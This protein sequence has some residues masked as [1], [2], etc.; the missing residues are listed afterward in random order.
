MMRKI[1][2]ALVTVCW[3]VLSFATSEEQILYVDKS[4][5]PGGDGE[6]P[7]TAFTTIAAALDKAQAGWTVK[8][9]PGDYDAEEAV[10]SFGYTNRVIIAKKVHLVS[11]QGKDVTHIVG[12]HARVPGSTT[13]G[14]GPDAVRCIRVENA[15]YG[16]IIE[17]FTLRD[18]ACHADDNDDRSKGGGLLGCNTSRRTYLVDCV[19]SNC[20]AARGGTA[21]GATVVRS[22]LIRNKGGNAAGRSSNF[23]NALIVDND[24]GEGSCFYDCTFFGC[25]VA[26]NAGSS[27]L[28]SMNGGKYKIYNSVFS[29]NSSFCG[30]KTSL[31]AD[32]CVL[33]APSGSGAFT[34]TGTTLGNSV[35]SLVDGY[36]F[37]APLVDDWRLLPTDASVGL[38][39]V[40]N[41]SSA[42][43]PTND[44]VD[45]LVDL[46]GISYSDKET[47]NAGALQT[48]AAS[49]ATG[50]LQFSVPCVANG[51]AGAVAGLYAFAESTPATFSVKPVLEDGQRVHRI[52]RDTVHGAVVYPDLN[53]LFYLLAPPPGVIVT[54]TVLLAH[55]VLYVSETGTDVDNDGLDPN[56]P[57][58]TLQKAADLAQSYDVVSAAA[59]TYDEGGVVRNGVSNRLYTTKDIRIVGAGIGKSFIKGAADPDNPSGKVGDGRGPKACRCVCLG[60]AAAVQGFTLTDGHTDY[61]DD[62]DK[63]DGSTRGGGFSVDST[64]SSRPTNRYLLDCAVTNCSGRT[65]GGVYCGTLIRCRISDCYGSGGGIRYANLVS[66]VIDHGSLLQTGGSES[67]YN[68][69]CSANFCTFIENPGEGHVVPNAGEGGSNAG[70]YVTNSVLVIGNGKFAVASSRIGANAY[71][72]I[73]NAAS[74]VTAIENAGGFVGDPLLYAPLAGDGRL[75]SCSRAIGGGAAD[76]ID[77]RSFTSGFGGDPVLFVDGQPTMGAFQTLVDAVAVPKPQ[78]GSYGSLP[79][80][81]GVAPGETLTITLADSTRPCSGFVVNGVTNE[82]DAASFTYTGSANPVPSDPV[83]VEPVYLPHWYVDA[84][85]GDDLNS[86]FTAG[87]AKQSLKGVMDLGKSLYVGDTVHAAEGVY[88]NGVMSFGTGATVGT[89]VVI[90]AGVTLQADG[91]RELTIIEGKDATDADELGLGAD[92]VRCVVITDYRSVLKGFTIRGGRTS[93]SGTSRD[94]N[95]CGG[96]VYS[97]TA[98]SGSLGP[99]VI[100]CVITNCTAGY[101][102]GGYG[103]IDYIGSL[104]VENR[105]KNGRSAMSVGAAYNCVFTGNRGGACVQNMGNIVNCTFFDNYDNATNDTDGTVA[106]DINL[107]EKGSAIYNTIAKGPVK[108]GSSNYFYASNCLFNATYDVQAYHNKNFHDDRTKELISDESVFVFSPDGR[109]LSKESPAVDATG[110]QLNADIAERFSTR[111]DFTTDGVGGQRV[112]NGTMD[113]GACEY[114]WRGE[115]ACAIG[116]GVTVETASPDVE[117]VDGKVRLTDGCALGGTWSIV[118]GGKKAKCSAGFSA[119]GE[120]T[121]TGNLDDGSGSARTATVSDGSESIAFKSK[122]ASLDWSAEYAGD[123]SGTVGPFDAVVGGSLIL[124]R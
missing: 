118:T 44:D 24:A 90:P 25:T 111:M 110:A 29:C 105:A 9:A 86:G 82:S 96:G 16:T 52:K 121:L 99:R 95:T 73:P 39:S 45:Y 114:D 71:L 78:Y 109:L 112:Y 77:Y 50:A 68:G 83:V 22:L 6:T 31:Q 53:D 70:D 36:H 17:G 8:V 62:A 115:Y 57:L 122:D 14:C 32:G 49:P 41:L 56:R 13:P 18:G 23:A 123:G 106:Y 10:D 101:G 74:Y 2:L 75:L 5:V 21:Y 40:S 120:G 97:S 7:E 61:Q 108:G 28:G 72:G 19:V 84:V 107:P 79:V 48:P 65:G 117:L 92:A 67:L 100:D 113:I 4:A 33:D 11:T 80:T 3:T 69:G 59:G 119:T 102:G 104:F 60:N 1:L 54:N 66:C 89:R 124:V 91:R 42:G 98:S 26:G 63:S 88:T 103:R 35:T 81:N 34:Y 93:C 64:G 37:L 76:A 12:R 47:V 85:N 15:A 58:K 27:V 46:D 94:L 20:V 38:A 43:L 51:R 87:S 116:G 55:R 30:S